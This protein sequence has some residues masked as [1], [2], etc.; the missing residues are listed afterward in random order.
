MFGKSR[1]LRVVP[2]LCA[3]LI[4]LMLLRSA[5]VSDFRLG[6]SA[7]VLIGLSISAILSLK[8]KAT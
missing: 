3:V 2:A 8:R 7:G 5:G 4:A 6:L 1:L